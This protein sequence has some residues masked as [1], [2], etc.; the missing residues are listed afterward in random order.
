[1]PLPPVLQRSGAAGYGLGRSSGLRRPRP[2]NRAAPSA[3]VG[4][5][6]ERPRAPARI[7]ASDRARSRRAVRQGRAAPGVAALGGVQ[8]LHRRRGWGFP[9]DAA[10]RPA[11][12]PQG[13]AETPGPRGAAVR[14]QS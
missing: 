1:E 7:A 5:E 3:N 4:V 2:A 13:Y 8:R 9:L 11:D 12:G 14:E 6:A 10:T